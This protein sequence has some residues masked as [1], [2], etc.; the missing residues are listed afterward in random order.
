MLN[1]D[2]IPMKA[3]RLHMRIGIVAFSIAGCQ[4]L[5]PGFVHLLQQKNG[6]SPSG[7]GYSRHHAGGTRSNYDHIPDF[8]SLSAHIRYFSQS[9]WS[10]TFEKNFSTKG[11]NIQQIN[12]NNSRGNQTV[13]LGSQTQFRSSVVA[14]DP[15]A[16]RPIEYRSP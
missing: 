4:K 3:L 8:L 12:W 1:K 13:P 9:F 7:C 14:A 6:L 10:L 16:D 2:R 15:L 11:K 5:L